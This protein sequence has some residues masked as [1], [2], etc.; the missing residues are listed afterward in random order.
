[1]RFLLFIAV[2]GLA[3]ACTLACAVA[4]AQVLGPAKQDTGPS[5]GVAA[6]GSLTA[7]QERGLR[8]KDSFRECADCPEMVVVPAGAYTMGSPDGEKARVKDEGPQHTVT[9]R[10]PFAVGR[11]HVTIEQFDA[12][13]RDTG[14]EAN[15]KC[16]TYEAGKL[17]EHAGQSWRDPGFAQEPS[18]PVV[19]VS[20]D[21]ARAYVDWLARKT[22]RPYRLPTEAEWEYAARSRTQPGAYP[23]FWFGDDDKDFCQNGNGADQKARDEIDWARGWTIV[24]CNDGYAYTSPSGRYAA[25]AFGLYDM[26]GNA[27]QWMADCWN[28][29]YNGAPADGAAWTTGDCKIRVVRGGSWNGDPRDL[30]AARRYGYAGADFF[31]GLRVARTLGT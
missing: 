1:V 18:H 20:F 14:Y 2:A 22:G 21:D 28:G 30:R 24:P 13:V 3:L 15:S 16:R 31:I 26:A 10:R 8:A 23:R 5:G 11:L 29:A 25:N 19:C 12:F 9:I 17:E 4:P 6:A 27:W 7:Q